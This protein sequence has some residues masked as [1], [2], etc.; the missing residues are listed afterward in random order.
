MQSNGLNTGKY[1]ICFW[2]QFAKQSFINAPY[3]ALL[4][5]RKQHTNVEQHR[6][7]STSCLWSSWQAL[8]L[9]LL[10]L[11]FLLATKCDAVNAERISMHC[12]HR[13]RFGIK[14]WIHPSIFYLHFSSPALGVA[15]GS[16]WIKWSV[17]I[18]IWKGCLNSIT[19]NKRLELRHTDPADLLPGKLKMGGFQFQFQEQSFTLGTGPG[20]TKD[21]KKTEP[22]P[23]CLALSVHGW[24]C[25]VWWPIDS[26]VRHRC[27]PAAPSGDEGSKAEDKFHILGDATITLTLT[28]TTSL[29]M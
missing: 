19:P 6:W 12:L 10:L 28:L 4:L 22:L 25:G 24:T 27:R 29:W 8:L 13:S 18:N 1:W 23:P 11:F 2:S 3:E 9:L 17:Y 16:G 14:G 5:V 20:Q 15:E 26:Q 7:T 21:W